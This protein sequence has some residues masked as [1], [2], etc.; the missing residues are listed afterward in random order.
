LPDSGDPVVNEHLATY[1]NDHLAGSVAAI[2]LLEHL[3]AA[4][5]GDELEHFFTGLRNDIEADRQELKQL[6]D[7]LKIAQS[8]PRKAGAWIAGKFAE[9]KMR[10]DDSAHGPL[11][12]LESLEAVELG[13]T[14]KLAL[15]R[16]LIAAAEIAAA[17]RDALDYQRLAR[18]ATEQ[19]ERVEFRRLEAAKASFTGLR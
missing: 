5:V 13:I 8:R 15:W 18:R 9:L 4:Y 3:Q 19:I 14:G 11:R 1:L 16:A 7:Q 6:M 12:L 17:L 2:E 10:L